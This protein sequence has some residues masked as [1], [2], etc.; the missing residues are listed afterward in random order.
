MILSYLLVFFAA[1]AVF[2]VG[3][4][5]GANFAYHKGFNDGIKHAWGEY[6]SE[7]ESEK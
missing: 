1:S 7:D 2:T 6:E 5:V 4:I 3:Y